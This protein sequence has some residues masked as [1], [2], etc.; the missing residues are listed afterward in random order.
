MDSINHSLHRLSLLTIVE[1]LD[2]I[3]YMNVK[4]MIPN[5]GWRMVIQT[6][7]YVQDYAYRLMFNI[8]GM[9]FRTLY[10]IVLLISF[11]GL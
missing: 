9:S 7:T 3:K 4:I 11:V 6:K 10:P 2:F 8:Y 1:S 5:N